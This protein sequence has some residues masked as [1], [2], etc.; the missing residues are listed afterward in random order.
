MMKQ[1]DFIQKRMLLFIMT[2][3][4]STTMFAYDFEVDGIFYNILSDKDY[5]LAVTGGE[6]N[7]NIP[8]NFYYSGIVNI[9]ATV[10]FHGH[11]YK[12]VA[13]DD[14]AFLTC[15]NVSY[16]VLPSTLKHIGKKAFL[17]CQGLSS[18][19][20]PEGLISIDDEA[21]YECDK[22]ES[23]VLPKSLSE[24]G[25]RT[26]SH[27]DNLNVTVA[28]GNPVFTINEGLMYDIRNNEVVISLPQT[29]GDIVLSNDTKSIRAYAFCDSKNIRSVTV[30]EGIT[31]IE[32]YTF[33]LSQIQRVTLPSSITSLGNNSFD[34]CSNLYDIYIQGPV[35]TIGNKAFQ[36]CDNLPLIDLP[37]TVESI[38]DYAFYECKRLKKIL[39]PDSLKIIGQQAFKDCFALEN[40]VFPKA[41]TRIEFGAFEGCKLTNIVLEENITEIGDDAFRLSW[42]TPM[43]ISI[44]IKGNNVKHIGQY[45]FYTEH[46][47]SVKIYAD[48][49]PAV[50]IMSFGNYW[51]DPSEHAEVYSMTIHV[52]KGLKA[53]YKGTEGWELY[54][55]IDDLDGEPSAVIDETTYSINKG[56]VGQAS[57]TIKPD[58][59]T[60]SSIKWR[61]DNC[62][63]VFI[64]Q[65]TGQFIGLQVGKTSIHADIT[66]LYAGGEITL[67]ASALVIVTEPSAIH[68]IYNS[69]ERGKIVYNLN[70]IKTSHSKI[71]IVRMGNGSTKK[72]LRKTSSLSRPAVINPSSR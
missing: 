13:I 69:N 5:T 56:D 31:K 67:S 64:D 29:G 36:F 22:L 72:V 28:D 71:Q 52:K 42:E 37:S 58:A 53:S 45:A 24:I 15:I 62:D 60:N 26:F 19:T 6:K 21:F 11:D 35:K 41:L 9:P 25:V 70:G 34:G 27:C 17:F 50:E 39:L 46:D 65:S 40:I 32:D 55:I 63:I 66:A 54:N 20:L 43:N 48:S 44:T 68:N 4:F 33:A 18:L 61:S 59:V 38:G 8:Y 47:K 23:L 51:G 14:D 30:N 7:D 12:V 16:I 2:F 3:V 57:V 10:P 49:P 1:H